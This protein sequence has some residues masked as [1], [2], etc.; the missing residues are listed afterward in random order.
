[1]FE[2]ASNIVEI[3]SGVDY[4]P[5][6]INKNPQFM[7]N[8]K[9]SLENGAGFYDKGMIYKFVVAVNTASAI[10][11]WPAYADIEDP[12]AGISIDPLA[13]VAGREYDITVGKI[14][15]TGTFKAYGY[16]A[17][18]IPHDYSSF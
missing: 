12:N 13:F 17:K 10:K 3:V 2:S 15:F 5:K 14:T 16:I 6:W 8:P 1:M 9:M 11:I 7:N 4:K 18:N